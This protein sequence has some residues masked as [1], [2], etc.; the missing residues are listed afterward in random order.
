MEC[1]PAERYPWLSAVVKLNMSQQ[2]ALIAR[3]DICVTGC[4]KHSTAN[5]SKEVIIPLYSVLV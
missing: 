3:R 5:Q 1:S 4:I 2:S